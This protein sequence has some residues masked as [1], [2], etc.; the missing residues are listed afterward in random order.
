MNFIV[1]DSP[2]ASTLV[3]SQQNTNYTEKRHTSPRVQRL[4]I[5]QNSSRHKPRH[6]SPK[7]TCTNRSLRVHWPVFS[8][9]LQLQRRKWGTSHE[10]QQT[11]AG[12]LASQGWWTYGIDSKESQIHEANFCQKYVLTSILK[13]EMEKLCFL[14]FTIEAQI[15]LNKHNYFVVSVYFSLATHYNKHFCNLYYIW[16]K[17]RNINKLYLQFI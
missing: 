13:R 1:P 4:N 11:A 8:A 3:E 17:F 12:E 7:H 2:H 10:P 6:F 15:M 5:Q 9:A 16:N 14:I